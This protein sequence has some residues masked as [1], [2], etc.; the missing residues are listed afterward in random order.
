MTRPRDLG[1]MARLERTR[2][3]QAGTSNVHLSVL[4]VSIAMLTSM[5]RQ[6]RPKHVV[7]TRRIDTRTRLNTWDKNTAC[8]AYLFMR[9]EL[10]HGVCLLAVSMAQHGCQRKRYVAAQSDLQ[11]AYPG[12]VVRE[13][14]PSTHRRGVMGWSTVTQVWLVFKWVVAPKGPAHLP[15][16]CNVR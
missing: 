10:R 12:K 16:V 13:R 3:L 14:S 8:A 11:T 1:A 2:A 6:P 7:H 15:I 9:R 5:T 4:L